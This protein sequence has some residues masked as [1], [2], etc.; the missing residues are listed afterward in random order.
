MVAVVSL[1]RTPT[2]DAGTRVGLSRFDFRS[3]PSSYGRLLKKTFS[4]GVMA[5]KEEHL[6][7]AEKTIH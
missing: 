4:I 2:T 7:K 6:F 1:R 3:D 5:E